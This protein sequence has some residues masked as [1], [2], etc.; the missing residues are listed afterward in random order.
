MVPSRRPY[1]D[2]GRAPQA[3]CAR[4]LLRHA[5]KGRRVRHRE[6]GAADGGRQGGPRRLPCGDRGAAAMNDKP[7]IADDG[8]LMTIEEAAKA[9]GRRV[10]EVERDVAA[11][12]RDRAVMQRLRNIQDRWG[13][14]VV[15]A[16]SEWWRAIHPRS[17]RERTRR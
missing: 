14:D 11:I 9:L 2:V 8:T 3:L 10:A 7:V 5:R 1:R 13:S 6:A 16:S 17:F 12:Q 15:L 4:A